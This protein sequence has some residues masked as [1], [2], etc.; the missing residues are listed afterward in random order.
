MTFVH[1]ITALPLNPLD[2]LMP[3]LLINIFQ[4]KICIN[5]MRVYLETLNENDFKKLKVWRTFSTEYQWAIANSFGSSSFRI[6]SV[7]RRRHAAANLITRAT[8][9]HILHI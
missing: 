4:Y 5:G 7:S 9:M 1:M 6:R 8:I 2:S 3:Q